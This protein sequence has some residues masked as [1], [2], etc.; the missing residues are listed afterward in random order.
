[1]KVY[2]NREPVS[3][4]WGGGN[5][6][7]TALA[8]NLKTNGHDVVFSLQQ[9]ID[10]IFC[11]DPR[12][13]NKNEWYQTFLDYRFQNNNCKI[14]QRVGDIG[15]HGKPELTNLVKKS[16]ILSDFVI[17]PSDWARK[18]IGYK[19]KNYSIIHNAPNDKFLKSKV[20]KNTE[21]QKTK[22]VTHHWSNNPLKGFDFYAK[23]RD[24]IS[25]N[26][27]EIEFTYIGRCPEELASNGINII[28]PL[29][30]DM[31]VSE[32]PKYDIY[33]T[34]SKW[35]AGANHV[36]EA[37]SAGLPVVYHADGGSIP[38]YCFE[39]GIDY[40][41]F[42]EMIEA[43]NTIKSNFSYYKNKLS[44]FDKKMSTTIIEYQD[45]ISHITKREST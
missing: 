18:T 37:M 45:I 2:I 22:I 29:S 3:G 44:K 11:F 1:V 34:A 12:P 15:T 27:K 10:V 26:N 13:N 24:Y 25:L 35:E 19:K 43:I 16:S 21:I 33:L 4:P 41:N 32:L 30:E 6:T 40:S 36:L 42:D 5:K 20:H 28:S 17:F 38:E 31:L 39:F 9:D 23:L 8:E 14:I 7:V